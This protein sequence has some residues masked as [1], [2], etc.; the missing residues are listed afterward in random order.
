[1]NEVEIPIKVSGIGA[2]KAELKALKGEIA[3][4]TDPADILRLSQAAGV[5]KDQIQDANDAVNVFSSGSKFEQASMGF[6]GIGDSIRSMDFE[7]AS[8]KAKVFA[9]SM[10]NIKPDDIQKAMSGLVS[11]IG[12]VGKAFVSLGQ[13]LLAN[14]I[15][16]IAAVIAAVIAIV[17]V[18]MDKLGY[19]DIIME[20]VGTAF[21]AALEAMNAFID[22][23][24]L[25]V[26]ESEQFKAVQETNTAALNAYETAGAGAI[27][28]TNE[29]GNAFEMAANGIITKKEALDIY[30]DKLG[31]TFGVATN[32]AQAEANYVA[33][34]KAYIDATMAR[35]RADVFAKKAAEEEAKA[36]TAGMKDQTTAGDKVTSWMNKNKL[37]TVALGAATGGLAFA[38][39]AGHAAMTTS[40]ETLASKQKKRVGEKEKEHLATAEIYKK[41][42]ASS[43]E[44]AIGL[45]KDNN[46]TIDSDK[47]KTKS[48]KGETEKR[49]REAEAEA[50]RLNDLAVKE[51]EN[52]I[53]REDAQF[54]L[55]NDLTLTAQQKEEIALNQAYD[56]KNETAKGNEALE[57][58]LLEKQKTDL[59]AI[60][61]KY[62][63]IE[64][65]KVKAAEAVKAKKLVEQQTLLDELTLTDDEKKIAAI[66]AKYL[67]EQELA[68]GHAETLLA[69]K[70]KHDIDIENAN[71]AAANAAVEKDRQVRD[72]KLGFAKDTVDGLANLGGLLIKDQKK[73]EKF[74]KA[75][76]LIQIGIDTA[77]AI[78]A[79]VAAANMNPLNSVT[80][81]GAGIAQFAAG[82]IQIATNV[83]KAKQILSSPSS[84]PSAG[85]GGGG[86]DT[87]GTSAATALPQAA[88]LFG[89]GNNSNTFNAGGGSTSGGNNNMT[90]TAI[91]SETQVTN[92][93]NKINMI[94]KNAEL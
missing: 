64:E 27:Q 6:A 16:L 24:G 60:R 34:T 50:K 8:Q 10:G 71:I 65:D 47:K 66:E 52:R 62:L 2:I 23:M 19:L 79:L 85:G 75:S 12:S 36:L 22:S 21:D 69:L 59:Q 28:V 53:K 89:Q 48:N 26:T 63:K 4:A 84:T 49:I 68:N 35:A 7:E 58:V 13:T 92:V 41:E 30:N 38:V 25:A 18:L 57:K 54:D 72:A 67:K 88:Q 73:L 37:A 51:N 32:Y 5:L 44:L 74:N 40:E 55:M 31:D 94:N 3:N 14:P 39:L 91:V 33:K 9:Q 81:G 77:K 87:G 11:T 82:I 80:A 61:D 15:Y 93:Q 20:G 56:K 42:M 90:V 76:A 43:L 70:N 29:V 45:E 86:G 1:M 83:A 78:S 46:I 17:V